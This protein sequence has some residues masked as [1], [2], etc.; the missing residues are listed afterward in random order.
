MLELKRN[1]QKSQSMLPSSISKTKVLES[2]LLSIHTFPD[3][4]PTFF[5]SMAASFGATLNKTV[6]VAAHNSILQVRVQY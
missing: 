3:I 1:K 4:D 2:M 5:L 6:V